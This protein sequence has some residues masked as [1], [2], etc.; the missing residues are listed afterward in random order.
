MDPEIN[1]RFF[2]NP[3]VALDYARAA[4]NVGLWESERILAERHIPKSAKILELGAGAGRVSLGLAEAGW[5][6]LTVSDF[7]GPM[8]EFARGVLCAAPAGTQ[9]EFAVEDAT[10]LSFGNAVFDAV[11]FA[12]NGWQMIPGRARRERALR[13]ISR[14]L[15]P[16]GVFMFTGHDRTHP[17]RKAHWLRERERWEHGEKSA[18]LDDFGDLHHFTDCGEMFI[19]SAAPEEV[20]RALGDAG[21][22]IVFSALR[23]EICEENEKVKN[24]S[25]DTRFW[26]AGKPADGNALP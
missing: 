7:A 26:I 2:S 9:I 11:I 20:A 21:F 24:F 5:K 17:A 16:G 6:N 1:R 10:E 3:A 12:F 4:V 15:K 13:E 8:I 23:S 18:E 25:D 19:H 14:V 22:R